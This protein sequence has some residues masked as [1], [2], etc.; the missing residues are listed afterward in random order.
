MTT[1]YPISVSNGPAGWIIEPLPRQ[2]E[3]SQ[4]DSRHRGVADAVY[5]VEWSHD[6]GYTSR[7]YGICRDGWERVSR[8]NRLNCPEINGGC[9]AAV[10]Q[11][12]SNRNVRIV[13]VL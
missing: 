8:A 12:A 9:G 7:R 10:E 11:V 1:T 13:E 4:H 5:V 2:C 6:C 3:H